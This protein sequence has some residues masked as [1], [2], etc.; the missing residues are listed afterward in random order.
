MIMKEKRYKEPN[1]GEEETNINVIYNENIFS[2]YTNRV[3]LQKK[4]YKLLGE[5]TQK[6]K[7]KKSITGSKWD[8]PLTDQVRI[9][10]IILKAKIFEEDYD[11]IQKQNKKVIQKNNFIRFL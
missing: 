4:L 2:L 7:I 10:R 8:I 11:S 1:K 9:S 6:F 3:S 5:P